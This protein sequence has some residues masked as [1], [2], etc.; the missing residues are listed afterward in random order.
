MILLG[1]LVSCATPSPLSRVPASLTSEST[2]LESAN[3]LL[4]NSRPLNEQVVSDILATD[5][6]LDIEARPTVQEYLEFV[7]DPV[8]KRE[9]LAYLTVIQ[10]KEGSLSFAE[11]LARLEESYSRCH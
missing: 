7:S 3:E 1:F 11:T 6:A 2:C 9:T 8:E 10:Q 5:L 4:L